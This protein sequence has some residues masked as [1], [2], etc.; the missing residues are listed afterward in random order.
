MRVEAPFD[1]GLGRCYGSPV[2]RVELEVGEVSSEEGTE[3]WSEIL[4]PMLTQR[5][6]R[7]DVDRLRLEVGEE[8]RLEVSVSPPRVV[9]SPPFDPVQAQLVASFGLPLI[10]A[11]A[12]VLVLHAAAV[13]SGESALVLAGGSGTGKSTALIG[14]MDAGWTPISEDVSVVDLNQLTP[15]IWPGPP[16]VRLHHDKPG[17]KSAEESFRTSEKTAWDLRP[18]VASA[19]ARLERLVVLEPPGGSEVR[20]ERLGRAD[21]IREIARHLVWLGRPDER[22]R[23][24]FNPLVQLATR[25]EVSRLRLPADPRWVDRLV[26]VVDSE[27]RG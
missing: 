6:V 9:A 11:D 22:S 4:N 20:L 5:L 23:R 15:T 19:P 7:T 27:M 18:W 24:L 3:V 12:P 16:W 21:A 1:C 25:L 14:L 13:S 8:R 26:A 17:P 2:A 10:L